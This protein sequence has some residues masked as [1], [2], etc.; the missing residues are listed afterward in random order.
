MRFRFQKSKIDVCP[1]M[2]EFREIRNRVAGSKERLSERESVCGIRDV[3]AQ[4]HDFNRNACVHRALRAFF[5]TLMSDTVN[6]ASQA[7]KKR[8]MTPSEEETPAPVS[9]LLV[10]RL[11][12]KARLPTRGSP[13]SAGYD[14]SRWVIQL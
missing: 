14:L 12:D 3:T 10:K 8:K 7:N 11:S 13:L 6:D 9:H 1:L 5:I 2:Y 4:E